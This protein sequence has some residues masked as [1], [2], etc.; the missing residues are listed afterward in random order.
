MA[1][2]Q[3]PPPQ[4]APTLTNATTASPNLVKTITLDPAYL[5]KTAQV[6]L[7]RDQGTLLMSVYR[8]STSRDA[9]GIFS[10]EDFERTS[11]GL[12]FVGKA[13]AKFVRPQIPEGATCKMIENIEVHTMTEMS[14]EEER[15]LR[16]DL[17][18]MFRG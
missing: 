15:Q 17:V 14:E 2:S 8:A 1:K 13:D 12:K 3:Y 5:A 9:L 18:E 10:R 16:A 4:V 6:V 7:T 11:A